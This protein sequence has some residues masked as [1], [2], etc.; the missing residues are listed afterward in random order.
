MA[1]AKSMGKREL[2]EAIASGA[3]LSKLNASKALDAAVAALKDALKAGR[4]VTIVG[5][6]TFEV[7]KRKR[8][9][10]VNPRTGEKIQIAAKKVPAFKAS[11]TLKDWVAG[12]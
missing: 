12:K 9:T 6:G 4:K 10:G 1:A 3:G 8:R 5:F 7:R 11:R 2:V